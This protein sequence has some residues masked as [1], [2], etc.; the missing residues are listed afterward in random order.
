MAARNG[1]QRAKVL[2]STQVKGIIAGQ[3]PLY[4]QQHEGHW[5]EAGQ[6]WVYQYGY[7]EDKAQ[8]FTIIYHAHGRFDPS[9]Y[10]VYCG[11]M[12]VWQ[13][14]VSPLG[15]VIGTPRQDTRFGPGGKY[16]G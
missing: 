8:G 4:R 15:Y 3:I 10:A 12:G 7:E 6:E 11:P 2:P 13:V 5:L 16:I 1:L 9:G 14:N